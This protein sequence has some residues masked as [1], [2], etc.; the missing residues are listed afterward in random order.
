M[1]LKA[2]GVRALVTALQ[3]FLS[4]TIG[5]GVFDYSAGTLRTAAV[6]AIGAGLSVIYNA[7]T[8]YLAKNEPEAGH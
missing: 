1:N 7:L 2:I 8:Q 3:V 5:A 4:V 6:S